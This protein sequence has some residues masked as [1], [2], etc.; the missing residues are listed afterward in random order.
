MGLGMPDALLTT[1]LLL[2][3]CSVT[4]NKCLSLSGPVKYCALSILH[5]IILLYHF[6]VVTLG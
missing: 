5:Y 6:S 2:L 1:P 3:I 4:L